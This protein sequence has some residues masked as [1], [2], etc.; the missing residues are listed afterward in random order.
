MSR[1]SR[2]FADALAVALGLGLALVALIKWY[3]RSPI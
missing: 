3:V 2:D 1:Q